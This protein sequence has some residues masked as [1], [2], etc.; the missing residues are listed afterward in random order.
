MKQGLKPENNTVD[1]GDA[2]IQYLSYPGGGPPLVLLH[3]TGFLPWLWHPI[4]RAL[5]G[6]F[7]ILAPYFCDPR[8]A[9]P[10]DGGLRWQQLAEDLRLFCQRLQLEAP[11]MVGHSMGGT[12][13]TLAVA[14]DP[15]LASGLVLIE[16]IFLPSEFYCLQIDVE[17]HPLASK[18]IRRRNHW[19]DADEARAY[20]RGKALFADW[21]DEILDLYVRH[22]M[23]GA[24][25]GGLE[26]SC[27]PRREAA[28]FMG[29]GHLDP[30]PL[31][32]RVSCPVLVVE[33]EKS[34]NRGHIDLEKAA[35]MF[36]RGRFMQVA[37]AGHLIPMERPRE[38]ARI[39]EAFYRALTAAAV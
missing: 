18:S 1:I 13:A 27:H 38:T 30:W 33:G 6:E 37:G 26:L 20:L 32:E 15:G 28:L 5:A 7:T 21:D 4:A 34:G 9:A 22:G 3:A 2:E 23:V 39:I 10:E 17:Q 8:E 29:G 31:L 16:P 14:A 19:A 12:V 11:L 24:E 36:P 35:S 25:A